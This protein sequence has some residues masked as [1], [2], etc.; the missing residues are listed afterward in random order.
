MNVLVLYSQTPGMSMIMDI[1]CFLWM[2]PAVWA[3]EGKPL[4]NSVVEM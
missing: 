4:S 2:L 1:L 3:V